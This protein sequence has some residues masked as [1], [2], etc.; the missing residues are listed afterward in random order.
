[1]FDANKR[2]EDGDKYYN[3]DDKTKVNNKNAIY[4]TSDED[5]EH[6]PDRNAK[7]KAVFN[8]FHDVRSHKEKPDLIKTKK[9]AV[10]K[11]FDDTKTADLY[12]YS[13]KDSEEMKDML[14]K[15]ENK[16][17]ETTDRYDDEASRGNIDDVNKRCDYDRMKVLKSYA[18]ILNEDDDAHSLMTSK[19]SGNFYNNTFIE[20]T[21]NYHY[22]CNPMR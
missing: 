21:N 6:K 18:R 9:K 17:K 22:R 15:A 5:Y 11:D 8:D 4:G 20:C 7:E 12:E 19:K 2:N 3:N 14:K 16:L 13:L 10:F 1:M